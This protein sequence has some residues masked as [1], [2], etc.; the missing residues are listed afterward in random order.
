MREIL[1]LFIIFSVFLCAN[2]FA[3]TQQTPPPIP[4]VPPMPPPNIDTII[5]NGMSELSVGRIDKAVEILSEANKMMPN[6]PKGT[7]MYGFS[8]FMLGN[9]EEASEN[10]VDGLMPLVD[11]EKEMEEIR[12]YVKDYKLFAQR[13]DG[14]GRLINNKP[15]SL[16]LRIMYAFMYKFAGYREYSHKVLN[17]VGSDKPEAKAV[18]T[19]LNTTFVVKPW[20]DLPP[21]AFTKEIYYSKAPPVP[22]PPPKGIPLKPLLPPPRVFGVAFGIGGHGLT[23]QIRDSEKNSKDLLYNSLQ[24][25]VSAFFEFSFLFSQVELVFDFWGGGIYGYLYDNQKQTF[26]IYGAGMGFAYHLLKDVHL[27]GGFDPSVKIGYNAYWME[28]DTYLNNTYY[29]GTEE[30]AYGH[31]PDL[32]LRLEYL[33]RGFPMDVAF[34]IETAYKVL[35]LQE[36]TTGVLRPLDGG[37]YNIQARASLK[38]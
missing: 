34:G 18:K 5:S 32:S 33:F 7:L 10:I 37:S 30:V 19:L 21:P 17:S 27:K 14:L 6:Y 4:Q 24:G 16:K 29:L 22:P 11:V 15:E 3:E 20:I 2:I 8:L 38:F 36:E 13:V 26:N 9:F 1:S 25:D 31:G 12:G 35:I 23:G 28:R